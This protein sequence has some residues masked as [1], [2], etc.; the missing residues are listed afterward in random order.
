MAPPTKRTTVVPQRVIAYYRYSATPLLLF[1]VCARVCVVCVDMSPQVASSYN[2]WQTPHPPT[3]PYDTLCVLCLY[4]AVRRAIIVRRPLITP[5]HHT[6]HTHRVF[7]TIYSLS[8]VIVSLFPRALG[9]RHATTPKQK[10][11]KQPPQQHATT[12]TQNE[13]GEAIINIDR[14]AQRH[15]IHLMR[16]TAV[17]ASH[18]QTHIIS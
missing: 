15:A 2:N 17:G 6:P 3:A 4:S 14:G 8:R 10:T 18:Q 11:T 1:C 9:G 5:T 7:R 13:R 12:T 16:Y